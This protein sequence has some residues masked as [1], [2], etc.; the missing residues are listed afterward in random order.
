MGTICILLGLIVFLGSIFVGFA[1]ASSFL[2]S[3]LAM[4]FGITASGTETYI[5]VVGI[6]AFIGLL[7]C[8]N[9]VMHGLTYNKI[10]KLDR[11]K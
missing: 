4:T 3:T 10:S 7:I 11:R 6:C 8:L 2:N 1:G 5:I 9:L